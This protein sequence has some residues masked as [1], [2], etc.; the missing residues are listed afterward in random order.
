DASDAAQAAARYDGPALL[1]AEQART[2]E[3][4]ARL[5]PYRRRLVDGAVLTLRFVRMSVQFDP[6]TVE[7]LGDR[8]SGYPTLR[9]VDDWG[10]LQVTGGA[11][12]K[13]DWS[14]VVVAAPPD[15]GARPLTGDGWR[16]EL[17]PGW[18]VEPDARAGDLQLSPRP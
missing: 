18:T 3:R 1:A 16:L 17:A 9:V 15:R 12:I 7:P 14:A 4:E 11:L 6:N 13:S 5:A 10:L 2:A 8:G